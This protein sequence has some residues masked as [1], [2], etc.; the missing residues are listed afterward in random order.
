MKAQVFRDAKSASI[1]AARNWLAFHANVRALDI[2]RTT[3]RED[4]GFESVQV[5]MRVDVLSAP[6]IFRQ[7]GRG[8]GY[9]KELPQEGAGWSH[10]V[11]WLPEATSHEEALRYCDKY[12]NTFGLWE[13]SRH[14]GVRVS[15]GAYA[16]VCAKILGD[17]E[18]HRLNQTLYEVKGVPLSWGRTDVESALRRQLGWEA[19]VQPNTYFDRASQVHKWMARADFPPIKDQLQHSGGLIL[20]EKSTWKPQPKRASLF[21]LKSGK[22]TSDPAAPKRLGSARGKCDGI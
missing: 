10:K 4:A 19:T 7:S 1:A 2:F 21:A 12:P 16:E 3:I 8:G 14:Q 9:V 13:N 22:P 11:I 15:P 6:H 20:I 18:A 5:L 17:E